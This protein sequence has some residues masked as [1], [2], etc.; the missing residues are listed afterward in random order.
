MFDGFNE[1]FRLKNVKYYTLNIELYQPFFLGYFRNLD[2]DLIRSDPSKSQCSS[3]VFK[4]RKV[5]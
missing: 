2:M 3:C 4:L 1:F 5:T